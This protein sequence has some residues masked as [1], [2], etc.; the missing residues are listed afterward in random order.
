MIAMKPLDIAAVQAFVLVADLQSFTRAA[1][2]LDTTQSA[3]SIK[4]GKLEKQIGRRLLERSP[5]HV[6]LS[7]EGVG[8]LGAA[9]E[10]V[11]AHDRAAAAFE[12][13]ERKLVVGIS[14]ELV[15]SEL[16]S[17]LRRMNLQDPHLRMEMRVGSTRDLMPL[18]EKGELDAAWVLRPDD[19]RK[20][21][22][23]VYAESFSWFGTA[24]SL[25]ARSEP[26]PLATQGNACRIRKAATR[27]LD[28]AGIAWEE[29]FV[30]KGAAMIGAAAAAGL[31]I[32]V[33]AKRTAPSGTVDISRA[34]SLPSIRSQDVMLYCGLND[35]RSREALR[36]MALAFQQTT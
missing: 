12:I 7:A 11:S 21:G 26:L 14:H 23:A 34:L 1:E 6:R 20:H 10:L 5:R 16:P 15:G 19:R 30:G 31:A 2:V 8:F 25:P 35:R 22:K 32:A 33:L 28:D 18:Y 24:G 3:I 36:I 27:A 13:E 29:V 4:L 9:R 17:L